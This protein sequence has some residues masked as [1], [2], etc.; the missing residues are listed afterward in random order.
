MSALSS[1]NLVNSLI[2]G[3]FCLGATALS[4]LCRN[5]SHLCAPGG[6]I[7][8]ETNRDVFQDEQGIF[9]RLAGNALGKLSMNIGGDT[10]RPAPSTNLPIMP[11]DCG[12]FDV[13]GA[14]TPL[15]VDI[16]GCAD[17]GQ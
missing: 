10:L 14:S 16:M 2:A 3:K 9:R 17:S 11:A 6:E 15:R 8:P 4:D 7:S 5:G 13:G 1:T 12:N